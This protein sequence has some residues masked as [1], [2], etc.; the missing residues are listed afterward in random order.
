MDKY[1]KII[2]SYGIKEKLIFLGVCSLQYRIRKELWKKQIKN[3][4]YLD[5]KVI[6]IS[7]SHSFLMPHLQPYILSSF[8][9]CTTT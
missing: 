4:A 1:I 5:T 2:L 7:N 6:L 3:N 8:Y 9:S